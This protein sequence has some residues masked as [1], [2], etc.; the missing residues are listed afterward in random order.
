MGFVTP[1]SRT[2]WN[3]LGHPIKVP[4]LPGRG[5]LLAPAHIPL[6]KFQF[7]ILSWRQQKRNPP[8]LGAEQL[9]T[10]AAGSQP[11]GRSG[12]GGGAVVETPV[13][14]GWALSWCDGPDRGLTQRSEGMPPGPAPGSRNSPGLSLPCQLCVPVSPSLSPPGLL[15][16]CP[17]PTPAVPVSPRPHPT[18]LLTPPLWF[19]T[20]TRAPKRFGTCWW[21]PRCCP[22]AALRRIAAP[23]PREQPWPCP[24]PRVFTFTLRFKYFP[25]GPGPPV[26]VNVYGEP[27]RPAPQPL[28]GTPPRWGDAARVLC[29]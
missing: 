17:H 12:K 18:V 21:P 14:L 23:V 13:G 6:P 28:R 11:R 24:R 10:A 29:W 16:P 9:G 7:S 4:L 5:G 1:H 3:G 25:S 19:T 22:R 20:H 15:S 27:V 8:S 26:N 2:T